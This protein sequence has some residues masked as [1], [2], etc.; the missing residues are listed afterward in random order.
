MGLMMSILIGCVGVLE[1]LACLRH[2]ADS[3][4]I[5]I[6][7]PATPCL[8]YHEPSDNVSTHDSICSY[9]H[10]TDVNLPRGAKR[11]LENLHEYS[12]R[13]RTE[14]RRLDKSF[15]YSRPLSECSIKDFLLPARASP[16]SRLS[17][18][19]E[20]LVRASSDSRDD[21]A[22]ANESN[23]Y[24]EM[25]Y[26]RETSYEDAADNWRSSRD[27]PLSVI[28]PPEPERYVRVPTPIPFGVDDELSSSGASS[29]VGTSF[30]NDSGN[31]APTMRSFD[32]IPLI[33]RYKTPSEEGGSSIDESDDNDRHARHPRKPKIGKSRSKSPESPDAIA[34]RS[35]STENLREIE[36]TEK[37][38]ASGEVQG[39]SSARGTSQ[40][41]KIKSSSTIVRKPTRLKSKDAQ[42]SKSAENLTARKSKKQRDPQRR[43]S[44]ISVQT[45]SHLRD[46]WT[47]TSP[48]PGSPLIALSRSESR[49]SVSVQVQTNLED[50]EQ[51]SVCLDATMEQMLESSA[52]GL[53]ESKR[54]LT[55]RDRFGR[56]TFKSR[57][58]GSRSRD[59]ADDNDDNDDDD[60]DDDYYSMSNATPSVERRKDEARLLKISSFEEADDED[61]QRIRDILTEPDSRE[62]NERERRKGSRTASSFEDEEYWDAED[63]SAE[64]GPI[65]YTIPDPDRNKAFWVMTQP[66]KLLP[67][68]S[69]RC[70]LVRSHI[71]SLR[72]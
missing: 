43:K 49:R 52:V 64:T 30:D 66:T 23:D 19:F 40:R 20:Y 72:Q 61:Y 4:V 47:N 48:P 5:R 28:T 63:V 58:F 65:H 46:E 67:D 42:V 6:N 7:Q 27:R 21:G 29:D 62:C 34:D 41:K 60:D 15:D 17:P 45:S 55:A 22:E 11:K 26:E 18:D 57:R 24:K 9:S 13:I 71:A 44:D 36:T 70:T 37:L 10:S 31:E 1:L 32:S 54:D 68:V 14:L 69:L 51:L 38:D 35:R 2:V 8:S 53:S 33:R 16:D 3:V 12:L 56:R 59:K 39:E 50:L 25:R